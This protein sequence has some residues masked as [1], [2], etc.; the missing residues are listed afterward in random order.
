M[1]ES[2][3]RHQTTEQRVY[4]HDGETDGTAGVV[5]SLSFYVRDWVDAD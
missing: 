2:A 1:S 4:P 5:G 3:C